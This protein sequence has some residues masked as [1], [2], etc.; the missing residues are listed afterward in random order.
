LPA[1]QRPS[2]LDAVI[3]TDYFQAAGIPL[4]RGR[5]FTETDNANAPRVVLINQEFVHRHL[6]DQEPL[7]KQIHL[8]VAGATPEWSEI[9]GVVNNV[10]FYSEATRD[11]PQVYEPFL[12]RPVPSFSLMVRASSDPNTLT[13]DLR[14]AVAQVDAELPLSRV[15]SMP[16]LIERQRAGD[17]FFVRMLGS[18]ALLALILASIGIY[19]LVAFSVSQRTHEMGI[20]MALGA[21]S[22]DVLRMVLWEGLKMTALGGAIGLVMALPLPKIFDAMFYGLHIREPWLYFFVPMA[23]L[24]VAISATYI[25]ARRATR[26]DPMSAL[27][28]E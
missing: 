24:V 12:Q 23:L 11:D 21:R 17:P 26:V 15:M 5:A 16:A 3:T 14:G 18:F 7:G 27:R 10:K 19:G 4:L 6:Q 1:D 8:D 25:P 28:Q 9:I 2:A 22:P 13:S 20:R